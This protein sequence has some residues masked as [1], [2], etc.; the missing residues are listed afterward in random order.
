[1]YSDWEK[2]Y[3]KRRKAILEDESLTD[4]ERQNALRTLAGIEPITIQE[5]NEQLTYYSQNK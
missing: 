5:Y 3:L 4:F 1:M 2:D